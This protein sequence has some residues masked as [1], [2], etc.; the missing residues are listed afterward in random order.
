MRRF[1]YFLQNYRERMARP[2]IPRGARVLDVGCL[3]GGFLDRL[4]DHIGPSVGVDP[5]ANPQAGRNYEVRAEPFPSAAPPEDESFDSIVMLAVLEH[6]PEKDALAEACFRALRPGGRVIITVPST[7]VDPIM[8]VLC[9]A[10]FADGTSLE[11]HHG[12]DP[13]ETP[14][15]FGRHG[16][17]LEHHRRFQLGLNN[18]FVL[19][20]PARSPAAAPALAGSVAHA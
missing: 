3:E 17:E 16:F 8:A 1:D 9:A 12:Y 6:I 4:G 7:W 19:R 15:V 18:L 14:A 13:R 2:W 20:K 5:Q 10:R 11:E